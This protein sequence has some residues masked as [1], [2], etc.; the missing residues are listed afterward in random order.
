MT[1]EWSAWLADYGEADASTRISMWKSLS[2]EQRSYLRSV[3]P[4]PAK[5]SFKVV[6]V[7]VCLPVLVSIVVSAIALAM[8]ALV[9]SEGLGN[10]LSG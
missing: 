1:P 3:L 10:V 9:L 2:R 6:L 5:W 7:L 8:A 4:P